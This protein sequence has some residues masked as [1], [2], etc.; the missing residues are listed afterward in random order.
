M[1][2]HLGALYEFHQWRNA[3]PIL[4]GAYPDEWADILSILSSF[5][6]LRSDIGEVG[7]KGG[8]K[9]LVAIRMDRLFRAAGWQPQEFDTSI[10]VKT[11]GSAQEIK[12]PT[13]EVDCFK[14]KIALELEWNNKTE[15]YDRDLNNFRLLFEL[16]VADV[17][18]IVTR[19]DELQSVFNAIG[20][21][22]SYGPTTT[23][24]S[25]LL[26]KLQGGAGGGCPVF[27]IGMKPTLY[28]DDI[29]DPSVGSRFVPIARTTRKRVKSHDP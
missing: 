1:P 8:G 3:I 29:A 16:R 13:H 22:S 28:L 10:V 12:S 18:V 20:K 5:R 26:R 6:I 17:G 11:G 2:E 7:T 4:R 9:S 25:K 21:G 27:V 19:C 15:F 24:L 14:G 23:I